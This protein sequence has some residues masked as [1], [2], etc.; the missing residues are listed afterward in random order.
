MPVHAEIFIP[1]GHGRPSTWKRL[2]YWLTTLLLKI[3]RCG[4]AVNV[5]QILP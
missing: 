3:T 2:A 4:R 1:T 5:I